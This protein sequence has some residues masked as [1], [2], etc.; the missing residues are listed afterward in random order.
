MPWWNETSKKDLSAPEVAGLIERFLDGTSR[1]PQ[2]WN[3]FVD[4]AQREKRIENYRR[5]CYE[6]DPLVNVRGNPAPAAMAELRSMLASL[7][8]EK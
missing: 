5:R 8:R 6:L 4:C 2:E 7:R 1:H 3:D